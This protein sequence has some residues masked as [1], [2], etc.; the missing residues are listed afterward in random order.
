MEKIDQTWLTQTSTQTVFDVFSAAGFDIFA[1]GGCVRNAVMGKQITDIDLATNAHPDQSM[2]LGKAAG[3]KVIP[4]GIDHGTVTFVVDDEPFEITTYRKDIDTD[5]RHATVD[6]A[7]N[8][9]DDAARRDFTMNALYADRTG[10][11][12]DPLGGLEDVHNRCVRFIG[13]PIER[14][15][16]DYLRILRFF[17]FYAIYGDPEN[18]FDPDGL[19]ACSAFQDGL[20]GLSK[21]RIGAEM[22]KLLDA[23]D[24]AMSLAVMQASGVLGRVVTASDSKSISL[25]IHLETNCELAPS[26]MR[27]LACLTVESQKQ[28]L[29]LSNKMDKHHQQVAKLCRDTPPVH[30]MAYRYGAQVALDAYLIHSAL[31]ETHIDPRVLNDI[32]IATQQIMPVKA[33]DLIAEFQGA[34]LGQKLAQLETSWIASHF[35]LTKQQLLA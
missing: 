9:E 21:E 26:A 20:E 27:R 30:E 11:I 32:E 33:A 3:I 23:P 35:S 8:M 5:G 29:V 18:G 22:I 34:A 17:R 6:F 14:I 16:E 19:A 28:S 24:P 1:V 13:D 7:E 31:L 4:T 15:K 10:C 25:L 2:T 12:F